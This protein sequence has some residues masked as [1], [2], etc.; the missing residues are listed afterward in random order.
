MAPQSI[1]GWF[2]SAARP[3]SKRRRRKKPCLPRRPEPSVSRSADERLELIEGCA[4]HGLAIHRTDGSL[5]YAID[6]KYGGFD[7][8]GVNLEAHT[9]ASQHPRCI[10]LDAA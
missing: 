9:R 7:R 1:F 6:G 3:S 8:L 10:H 4:A 2:L 5:A